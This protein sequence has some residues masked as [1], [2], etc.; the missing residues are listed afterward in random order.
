MNYIVHEFDF[1]NSKNANAVCVNNLVKN[2]NFKINIFTT[3]G[4]SKTISSKIVGNVTAHFI[5]FDYSAGLI[6]GFKKWSPIAEE[7]IVGY[8]GGEVDC[9]IVSVANPVQ[10]NQ[11]A[12]NVTNQLEC[13]WDVYYLDPYSFNQATRFSKLL[14]FYRYI[15]EFKH[16]S[17]ARKIYLTNELFEQYSTS[18]LLFFFKNKFIK[19][20][21]PMLD[22]QDNDKATFE[23]NS[24]DEIS[25]VYSGMFY[26][27]IR[28]P[29]RMF[30][31][32][33]NLKK[34]QPKITLYLYGIEEI[35]LLKYFPSGEIPSFIKCMNR[36]SQ[37][38]LKSVLNTC[39]FLVNIGN[40]VSNQL[41]SKIIDYVSTG[42]PILNFVSIDKDTSKSF[43][44]NYENKLHINKDTSI[45]HINEFIGSNI[46]K[47]LSYENLLASYGEYTT[48]SIK[49]KVYL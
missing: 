2:T 7:F 41:P 26:D 16:F 8:L 21:I 36:V 38:E 22:I 15:K 35:N 9:R 49:K 32:F 11:V 40:S 42:N 24:N 20:G 13:I 3:C 10:I 47:K 27:K 18:S 45:D 19:T 6:N 48:E 17:N 44:I 5:P 37:E 34:I 4:I 31:V 33:I 14:F 12:N 46:Y 1:E 30:E 43:L 39:H 23:N 25:I 28:N 29:K